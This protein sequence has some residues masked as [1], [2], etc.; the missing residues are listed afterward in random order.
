M[1][2]YL[3]LAACSVIHLPACCWPIERVEVA[4]AAVLHEEAVELA[5]LD[6]STP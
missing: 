6:L 2:Y 5:G 1:S 3:A 4:A